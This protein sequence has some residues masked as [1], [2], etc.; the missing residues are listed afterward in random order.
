M[1]LKQFN[2][3]QAHQRFSQF[4]SAAAN[5]PG[6]VAQTD[7]GTVVAR[8]NNAGGVPQDKVTI[9]GD[10]LNSETFVKRGD[11]LQHCFKPS[12]G[13]ESCVSHSLN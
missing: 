13:S 7:Q 6:G 5:A 11:M 8:S 9:L 3:A 4:K 2:P 10:T 1:D 12:G